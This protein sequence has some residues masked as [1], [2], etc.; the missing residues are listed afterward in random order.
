MLQ[1]GTSNDET[2]ALIN[3]FYK[4]LMSEEEKLKYLI[5]NAYV[6]CKDQSGCRR[7]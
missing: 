7:L 2:L 4:G 1:K 3:T 5:E 6:L